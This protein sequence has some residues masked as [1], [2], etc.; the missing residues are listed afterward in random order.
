M[1]LL[2]ENI[3]LLFFL[4]QG[5]SLNINP[6][7]W[8]LKETSSRNLKAKVTPFFFLKNLNFAFHEVIPDSNKTI[9]YKYL[10]LPFLVRSKVANR[11]CSVQNEFWNFPENNFPWKTLVIQFCNFTKIGLQHGSFP[12]NF[13]N[14]LS[15]AFYRKRLLLVLGLTFQVQKTKIIKMIIQLTIS[16]FFRTHFL[17]VLFN[18]PHFTDYLFAHFSLFI[19]LYICRLHCFVNSHTVL[20]KLYSTHY[21][22]SF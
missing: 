2:F 16:G 14:I 17:S 3:L 1:I 9:D 10:H 20:L 13:W 8:C 21:P 6:W 7:N 5:C 22:Y 12:V 4:D 11:S 15:T 19:Y 18:C